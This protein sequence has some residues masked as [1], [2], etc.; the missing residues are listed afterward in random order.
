MTNIEVVES[1]SDDDTTCCSSSCCNFGSSLPDH[2]S[3]SDS[4]DDEVRDDCGGGGCEVRTDHDFVDDND[5]ESSA[6][7]YFDA[8]DSPSAIAVGDG[9]NIATVM[10]Q[11][12]EEV[13]NG[14]EL[15]P[16]PSSE[17]SELS[18][19]SKGTETTVDVS[20]DSTTGS[21]ESGSEAVHVSNV[22]DNSAI[23]RS[24]PGPAIVSPEGEGLT[25]AASDDAVIATSTDE[26]EDDTIGTKTLE[27]PVEKKHI[28]STTTPDNTDVNR[29]EDPQA[30]PDDLALARQQQW[31]DAMLTLKK[32]PALMTADIL[33]LSLAHRAPIHVV[34]TMLQINP[35]SAGVPPSGPSALQVAIKQRCSIDVIECIIRACPYALFDSCGQTYAPLSLAKIYRREEIELI[36]LLSLPISYWISNDSRKSKKSVRFESA[37]TSTQSHP[38]SGDSC[39][40]PPPPPAPI[41]KSAS[42]LTTEEKRELGNMKLIV[43]AIV[44]SQKKLMAEA[45]ENSRKVKKL[46]RSEARTRREIAEFVEERMKKIAKSHLIAIEMKERAFESTVD[47]F[48]DK[49]TG[50][51][52]DAAVQQ[53]KAGRERAERDE[54]LQKT[55]EDAI[56]TIV[57]AAAKVERASAS[58][59]TKLADL[60][61][62]IGAEA[63]SLRMRQDELEDKIDTA[64]SSG[65]CDVD[66][67]EEPSFNDIA[68][69]PET[70]S[71]DNLFSDDVE[72]GFDETLVSGLYQIESSFSSE[73]NASTQRLVVDEPVYHSSASWWQ[74]AAVSSGNSNMKR[75]RLWRRWVKKFG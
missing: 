23:D 53:E 65:G 13:G 28:P 35:D 56:S 46:A 67:F 18:A 58:C 14:G 74:A 48:G 61:A 71:T 40:P 52:D 7:Q 68:S 47:S 63:N 24:S 41:L 10:P 37:Q 54:K 8:H 17:E 2:A 6:Q 38:T 60:S 26:D 5:D 4:S 21:V 19:G 12:P 42:H 59:E 57:A 16:T 72:C 33:N 34:S 25:A 44:K 3:R 45:E 29:D 62:K 36:D 66:V 30:Q 73:W 75:K 49:M 32:N 69:I 11:I 64:S 9:A 50:M 27:A 1:R 43:A 39:P 70:T 55:I 51:L 31:E 15:E 20:Y 22:D